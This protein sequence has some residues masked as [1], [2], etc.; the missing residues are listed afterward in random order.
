MRVRRRRQ[1]EGDG[2]REQRRIDRVEIGQEAGFTRGRQIDRLAVGGGGAGRIGG[3]ERIG[4]ED[5]GLAGA[6]RHIALGG[7]R[8]E[9]QALARAVQHDDFGLGIDRPAE[10]VTPS[11]PG[12]GGLAEALGALVGRIAAE[13][14][15]MRLQHGSD[16]RRNRM[17]R[18]A[19]RKIDR[20]QARLDVGQKLMQP[21]E[22]RAPFGLDG[23]VLRGG[24]GGGHEL[25]IEGRRNRPP[26]EAFRYHRGG[27]V[28]A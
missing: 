5:R 10:A 26:H 27:E 1:I 14:V 3:V 28:K 25:D 11:E 16:E 22:R 19:D 6:L 9:E 17:L 2:A 8:A 13:I 7:E 12:R 15:Q 18:L 23:C 20:G 24:G 4:N 21:H